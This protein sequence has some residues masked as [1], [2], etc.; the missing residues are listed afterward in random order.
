MEKATALAVLGINTE[1]PTEQEI[2]RA[3]LLQVKINHPD[4]FHQ[5]DEKLR[6][7]AE[8]QMKL[9]N[10]AH[11]ILLGKREPQSRRTTPDP[12]NAASAGEDAQEEW[13]GWRD[14][15]DAGGAEWDSEEARTRSAPEGENWAD[16]VHNAARKEEAQRQSQK[17]VCGQ[18]AAYSETDE[19]GKRLTVKGLLIRITL[20]YFIFFSFTSVIAIPLMISG[21]GFRITDLLGIPSSLSLYFATLLPGVV[22][23]IVLGVYW[24]LRSVK[25]G[26]AQAQRKQ[27]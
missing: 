22:P 24:E 20:G 5:G 15:Y 13:D 27:R 14:Y 7:H 19:E 17:Q 26:K 10:E 1:N 6:A 18:D 25:K 2:K 4:R 23:G 9:I 12:G 3:Y 11:E 8:E 16:Q 21:V